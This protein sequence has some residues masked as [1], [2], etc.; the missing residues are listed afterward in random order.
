MMSGG[1]IAEQL[2]RGRM[3]LDP[4]LRDV[5]HPEV[6]VE[7]DTDP[8]RL[9]H[10]ALDRA[11]LLSVEVVPNQTQATVVG[12][13]DASV[14]RHLEIAGILQCSPGLRLSVGG[15]L[16]VACDLSRAD[17]AEGNVQIALRVEPNPGRLATGDRLLEPSSRVEL[18]DALLLTCY[19]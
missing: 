18:L 14:G 8:D 15:R 7:I 9:A 12:R 16:V 2:A 13:I 6:A 17:G 4:S 3:L 1:E 11:Q 5:P 10:P 19:T